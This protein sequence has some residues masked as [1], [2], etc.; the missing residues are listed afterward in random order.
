M[1]ATHKKI[2]ILIIVLLTIPY[3]VWYAVNYYAA[4]LN[5]ENFPKYVEFGMAEDF[6]YCYEWRPELRIVGNAMR[7]A[8]IPGKRNPNCLPCFTG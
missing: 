1:T 7:R 3:P 4:G 2:L 5:P 8:G 6:L